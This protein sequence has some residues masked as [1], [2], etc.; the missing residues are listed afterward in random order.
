M[1]RNSRK[2][3]NA[4][5][6]SVSLLAL[7]MAIV[8]PPTASLHAEP[9]KVSLLLGDT[10]TG[11]TIEA[12]KAVQEV[13]RDRWPSGVG[14]PKYDG[15]SFYS[16]PTQDIQKRD[17]KHLRE[18]R[19]VILRV[20]D[21]RL[22]DAAGPALGAVSEEGGV[23]YAVGGGYEADHRKMGIRIDEKINAYYQTRV[24]EN[25]KNMILYA[26]KKDFSLDLPCGEPEAL[27]EVGIYD[28]ASGKVFP[29][30]DAYRDACGRRA[31][32]GQDEK[33]WVGV[34]FYRA[35]LESGQMKPLDAV[36]RSLE[37]QGF[38]VLS[39]YGHPTETALERIFLAPGA[40]KIRLLVAIGA[41]MAQNSEAVIPLLSKLRVPVINAI[42]LASQS[43]E[44]WLKSPVGLDILERGWQVAG[45]EMAGIIQPTVIASKERSVD[46]ETGLEYMAYR[47]IPERI[48]GLT[49]RV[50][51][52]INLQDKPNRDKRIALIY[53]NYPPGKQNIGAAYLNVLPESLYEIAA[54]L[55]SEGYDLK[56]LGFGEEG[57]ERGKER[58][59]SDIHRFARNIGNWAPGELDRMAREGKPVL[60][61]LEV[62]RKWFAELPEGFRKSVLKSWGPVEQSKVMVWQ[63]RGEKFLVLPAVLY[64]NILFAPQPSRGWEQ[65]E[66]KL[67]HDVVLPPHHQYIAFYLWLRHWFRADA[68]AHIG[69][70]GTHEWL[71]GKEVGFTRE[72][73]PE[74][75]IGD[76][77]NIYPYNVDNVAEGIQ[78]KRR[79]AAVVIDHMTP[80]FD[81]AGL[82]RELRELVSLLNDYRIAREKSPVLA[83]TKLEGLNTLARKIG[84][85][86][87][88]GLG[89]I[90]ASDVE[91][92]DD[93][94]TDIAEK[95]TPFGLHTFG[96]SPEERYRKSTVEAILSVEKGP[97]IEVRA[98]RAAEL[99]ERIRISGPRELNSFMDALAGRYISPGL[100][101]DP[102]R[103]PDSL[104]TGN[105]FYGFD[106]TRIPP[107]ATYELGMRLATELIEGYRQR[108]VAYPDKLTYNLWAEETIRNEG[109][110]ESQV[111]SLMGVRPKWDQR[112]RVTGIEAIPRKELGRQRIDVTLVP[113]G[114]Y[115]DIFSNLMVMLDDAVTLAKNQDENDNL[116]RVHV[117]KTKKMLMEKG[118]AEDK[119][120]RLAS[121]RIFTEPSGAYGTN[122]ANVIPKSNS[123]DNEKQ[124]ADVYFMRMSHLFGQGFWSAKEEE[125]SEDISRSLL[126][127]A[128]SGSKMVIHSRSSN[129][130]ATLDNNDFFQYLGGTTM[131]IRTLDGKTPEVYVTNLANPKMPKQETLE[132]VMGREMRSRY[133]NPE[134]IKAMMKEGYAGARFVDSVVGHLWGWQVTVPEA[135]DAAKWSEMYETYVLDKNGLDIKGLF[136]RARNMH[137]YQSL[138]AR[139]LETVRKDYWK[140]DDKVAEMLAR[141]YAQ[142]VQEVG[143]A[144]CDHTCNNPQLTAFTSNVL[145]SVPGLKSLAP[146][147]GKALDTV[148]QP[149]NMTAKA[150][151][152]AVKASDVSVS[153]PDTRRQS[154]VRPEQAP[155][156]KGQKVE[157]YE[158]QET[159]APASGSAPIPYLFIL[160]FLIFVGLIALG[161]RKK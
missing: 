158:M 137:A 16:Y 144:C 53:Y 109:V 47:P 15:V 106:P 97:G 41:K 73:P 90:T 129:L 118:I 127:S 99:E 82:N 125:G 70:H 105:N 20:R 24:V 141:E 75:L 139:M 68:V 101:E 66:N 116:L 110:M 86:K 64:G 69:T 134:W 120:E 159:G 87:D 13:I 58:L 136:R 145:L 67:Y 132:K 152:P 115:R 54:R 146:G 18:S 92:L 108:H 104:P 94:L 78:A 138:V 89:T 25:L 124:V 5:V 102:I 114:L 12:I 133:L 7:V 76:L 81:K 48:D 83:E 10:H 8:L 21:R 103:N 14:H 155:G 44:E 1:Y 63:V 31:V 71:P 42:A 4:G 148:K 49:A 93:Y 142:S 50:K 79:G 126:K 112:G 117:L 160:G 32:S 65:D 85:A 9:L 119:A 72:D 27:P 46:R 147:F 56:G 77:P 135:V 29:S 156:K 34:L 150:L 35:S 95:Q 149:A 153:A 88:L 2:S 17:L 100:G 39:A 123:W 6:L 40:P 91:T 55:N 131:A 74:V 140:A 36:V 61:P 30:V 19:L 161:F 37:A 107:R 157:G 28:G 80:P 22:V 45:S 60:I 113:S 23:I 122:L 52:W 3:R 128:L 59:F 57:P 62:Y 111:L 98:G 26:L 154:P 121:V 43:E 84:L 130:Y 33:P 38:N 11:T 96:K 151:Q 143:L 51:A